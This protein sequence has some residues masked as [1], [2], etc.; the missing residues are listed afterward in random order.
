MWYLISTSNN[1]KY[2]FSS[3]FIRGYVVLYTHDEIQ[4]MELLNNLCVY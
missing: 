2:V 4:T 3:A 1:I